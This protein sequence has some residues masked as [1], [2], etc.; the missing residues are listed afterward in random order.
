MTDIGGEGQATGR[1]LVARTKPTLVTIAGRVVISTGRWNDQLMADY[2]M[3]EGRNRWIKIGEL[4]RTGCSSNT[5][6]TKKR[7]RGYLSR[8]F[9][10]LRSRGEF[11][12]VNYHDDNKAASEVK[13]A[14]L[15]SDEDKKNVRLRLERMRRRKE[16]SQEQYDKS[17]ALLHKGMG[18]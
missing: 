2:V 5:I 10:V 1:K 15:T 6:A 3:E 4:A 7:V 16:M 13:I 14:D 18:C 8:L 12:A 9:M 17:V 11:L